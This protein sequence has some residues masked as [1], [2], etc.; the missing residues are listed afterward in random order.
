MIS[1]HNYQT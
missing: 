1:H